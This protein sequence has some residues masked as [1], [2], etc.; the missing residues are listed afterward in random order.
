MSNKVWNVSLIL[1]NQNQF[2][3]KTL[4]DI[5]VVDNFYVTFL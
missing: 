3:N 2:L 5:K 1:L 4:L